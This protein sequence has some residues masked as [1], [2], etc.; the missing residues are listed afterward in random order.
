MSP[1]FLPLGL[2][3]CFFSLLG[4]LSFPAPGYEFTISPGLRDP[5][6]EILHLSPHTL[7]IVLFSVHLV[8]GYNAKF[9][10]EDEDGVLVPGPHLPRGG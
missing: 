4:Y 9:T 10:S 8:W 5:S 2:S 7:E 6:Y 1:H 3:S